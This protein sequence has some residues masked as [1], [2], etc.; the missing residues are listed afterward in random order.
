MFG[1]IKECE[2]ALVQLQGYTLRFAWPQKHFPKS[3][4][5]LDGSIYWRIYGGDIEFGNLCSSTLAGIGDRKAY[6][7][8]VVILVVALNFAHRKANFCEGLFLALVLL[9]FG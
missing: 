3:F 2:R 6:F 4:Q 7:C 5:L 9:S 1:S 8:E